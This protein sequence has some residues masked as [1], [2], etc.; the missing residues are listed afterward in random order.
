MSKNLDVETQK[1]IYKLL[2]K[3]PGLFLTAIAEE[4]HL[5]CSLAERCL[6]SLE[7]TG[8]VFSLQE[9]SFPRRF[10]LKKRRRRRHGVRVR[11][12]RKIHEKIFNLISRNPGLSLSSIAKKIRISVQL[13][14]YHLSSMERSNRII[15]TKEEREYYRRYYIKDS[16]IGPQEKKIVALLRQEQLLRIVL[17]VL[18]KPNMQHKNLAEALG[19]HPSTLT[20]HIS[21]L[22]ESGI[23]AVVTYGREKGYAVRDRKE[24]TWIIRSYIFDSITENFKEMWDELDPQ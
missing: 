1:K 9:R 20:H 4:L 16:G 6:D 8:G 13:A 17:L 7:K 18:K 15:G 21:R 10:Y 19:I 14:D 22:D 5:E 23:L 24:I 11:R 2:S 12:T 3:H